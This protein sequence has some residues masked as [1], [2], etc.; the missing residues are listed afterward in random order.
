MSNE[1]NFDNLLTPTQKAKLD[2]MDPEARTALMDE[3][4]G[5][6]EETSGTLMEQEAVAAAEPEPTP[7]PLEG[8]IM[9]PE[10]IAEREVA[11][12]AAM[13][14]AAEPDYLL[15]EVAGNILAGPWATKALFGPG[16]SIVGQAV[17]E[18]AVSELGGILAR[19]AAGGGEGLPQEAINLGVGTALSSAPEITA[20]SLAR[21]FRK[22][23]KAAKA[24]TAVAK[25]VPERKLS[26]ILGY[27]RGS[28][29]PRE[30][31]LAEELREHSETLLDSG[32]LDS[33]GV[34]DTRTSTFK[35][36]KL[37]ETGTQIVEMANKARTDI[38]NKLEEVPGVLD[39]AIEAY[40][41]G[42]LEGARIEGVRFKDLD[43]SKIKEM[44]KEA[45]GTVWT[46]ES[47]ERMAEH[48]DEIEAH[49]DATEGKPE[50]TMKVTGNGNA[51]QIQEVVK[52]MGKGE[53]SI[54]DMRNYIKKMNEVDVINKAFDTAIKARAISGD[55]SALRNTIKAEQKITRELRRLLQDKIESQS[56]KILDVASDLPAQHST[57]L[58][59]YT[60]QTIRNLHRD[61][62]MMKTVHSGLKRAS[63]TLLPST[64]G[65]WSTPPRGF[66]KSLITEAGPGLAAEVVDKTVG[67][68]RRFFSNPEREFQVQNALMAEKLSGWQQALRPTE[69]RGLITTPPG[70]MT[71]A[72]AKTLETTGDV[73]RP[74]VVAPGSRILADQLRPQPQT[75]EPPAPTPLPRNIDD[76]YAMPP[77]AFPPEVLEDQGAA[78]LLQ[79]TQHANPEV[80]ELAAAQ[81]VEKFRGAF[82]QVVDPKFQGYDII[83]SG[84][85]A[86][87]MIPEQRDAYRNR[88]LLRERNGKLSFRVATKMIS[89]LNSDNE[90]LELREDWEDMKKKINKKSSPKSKKVRVETKEGT[91]YAF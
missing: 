52:K 22:Y 38:G 40:N 81:L 4:Y 90:V 80:R 49:W 71:G 32:F 13:T 30:R 25:E 54:S 44:E 9:T 83:Y 29:V 55:A 50:V 11:Q 51:I 59:E 56:K 63:D 36:G 26:D 23:S 66:P 62:A 82:E 20:K 64:E 24:P 2:A 16:K 78:Q 17:K 14:G 68:G 58:A 65:S 91:R 3:L 74:G 46:K 48:L 18:G 73:L 27:P 10:A 60:P 39:E 42:R 53:L 72:I 7:D 43:L 37:P 67:A 19:T 31:Q 85:T 79:E 15:E 89:K 86:K 45:K 70:M 6:V 57:R 12:E 88:V 84:D 34:Y 61:Y 21:P 28:G 8:S 77:E 75:L 33:S 47:G 87:I 41:K 1:L 35:P 5:I 76:L 69:F